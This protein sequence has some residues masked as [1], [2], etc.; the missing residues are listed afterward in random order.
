MRDN[1]RT[2]VT[3]CRDQ[4]QIVRRKLEVCDDAI[5][6]GRTWKQLDQQVERAAGQV[7]DCFRSLRSDPALLSLIDFADEEGANLTVAARFSGDLLRIQPIIFCL[8]V[9]AWLKR[10]A[11]TLV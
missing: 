4:V 2:T 8:D 3:N 5:S 1:L 9:E 6:L 10:I 11:S 7:A